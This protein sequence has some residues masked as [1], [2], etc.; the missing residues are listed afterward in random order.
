MKC[1]KLCFG[2]FVV[3]LNSEAQRANVSAQQILRLAIQ[4]L[5]RMGLIGGRHLP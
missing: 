5:A 3:L 1:L 4:P 2:L